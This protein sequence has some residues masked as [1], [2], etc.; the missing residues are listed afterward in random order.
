MYEGIQDEQDTLN[1]QYDQ[2]ADAM[3]AQDIAEAA[4]VEASEAQLAS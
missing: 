1:A 4:W 2:Q 3:L